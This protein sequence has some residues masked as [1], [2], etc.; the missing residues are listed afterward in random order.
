MWRLVLSTG[1]TGEQ[2]QNAAQGRWS[3]AGKAYDYLLLNYFQQGR[4]LFQK[5]IVRTKLDYIEEIKYK[6]VNDDGFSAEASIIRC[7]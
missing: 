5:E 1:F 3:T 7:K 6:G 2:Q 4:R